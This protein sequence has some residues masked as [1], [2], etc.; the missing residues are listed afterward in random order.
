MTREV[1]NVGGFG[2]GS[3]PQ[4]EQGEEPEFRSGFDAL[5]DRALA[6]SPH[7]ISLRRAFCSERG[8]VVD[9]VVQRAASR[10]A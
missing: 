9:D 8:D 1:K 2:S 10:H 4:A 7:A 6:L 3:S 5:C